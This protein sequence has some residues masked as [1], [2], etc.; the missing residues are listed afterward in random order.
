MEN[1]HISFISLKDVI[2]GDKKNSNLIL[3]VVLL[4]TKNIDYTIS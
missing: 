1:I 3:L 4:M 2:F